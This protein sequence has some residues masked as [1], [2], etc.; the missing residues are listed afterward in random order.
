MTQQNKSAK[1]PAQKSH[2]GSTDA[3]FLRGGSKVM[4]KKILRV[5]QSAAV[6]E[7]GVIEIYRREVL[8]QKTRTVRL[9]G[10]KC[11]ADILQTL[12]GYEVQA[13]RKRIQCP[14]LVTARYLKLFSEIGCHTIRLPYDPTLTARIIPVME[15]AYENIFK[16]VARIFPDDTRLRQYVLQKICALV[17]DELRDAT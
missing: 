6:Y 2:A 13:Q 8:P 9:L 7:G 16:T 17:R 10:T 14:D 12:L 5:S 3:E 11:S 1:P 4:H 15:A